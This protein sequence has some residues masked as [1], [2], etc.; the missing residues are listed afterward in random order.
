[1]TSHSPKPKTIYIYPSIFKFFNPPEVPDAHEVLDEETG[2]IRDK[3]IQ[4]VVMWYTGEAGDGLSDT[5]DEDDDLFDEDDDDDRS[6]KSCNSSI[7]SLFGF[8]FKGCNYFSFI[9]CFFEHAE[10]Q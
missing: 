3:I 8:S 1:M 2:I 10:S 5:I 9:P 4:Q 6:S 7:F